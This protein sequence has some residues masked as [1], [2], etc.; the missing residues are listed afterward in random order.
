MMW[1][2]SL[3]ILVV[4]CSIVFT[5]GTALHGFVVID[6]EVLARTMELAGA[7]ADPS[8][9]LAGFRAV[10]AVFV[11]ANALGLLALRAGNWLFWVV[12]AVNA[13]QAA[14][15]GMVPFEMFQAASETYGWVGILPSVVTDGGALILVLIMLGRALA[16]VRQRSARGTVLPSG[17]PGR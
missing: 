12:L 14:G 7:S 4:V 10:G 15:V 17:H 8:G 13:G 11:V 6:E 3:R 5:I 1:T 9:F 16:V 2:R